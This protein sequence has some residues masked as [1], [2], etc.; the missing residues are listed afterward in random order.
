MSGSDRIAISLPRHVL[1][2]VERVRRRTGETRSGLIQRAIRQMLA[3]SAKSVRVKQY[4]EGYLR[5]PEGEGEI[6][7]A[8]ASAAK[9]L[10]SEPW[11]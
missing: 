3:N 5:D 2:A 9:L 1:E 10:A 11:E 8:H 7:A 6:R 4:V